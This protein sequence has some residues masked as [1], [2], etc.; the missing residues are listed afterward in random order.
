MPRQKST[1]YFNYDAI[2]A[3]GPALRGPR[4]LAVSLSST[5]P[6]T[7]G[8]T[9][10]RPFS[11]ACFG[12]YIMIMWP[13]LNYSH[14][15]L[16]LLLFCSILFSCRWLDVDAHENN[17]V[18]VD[19]YNNGN[20]NKKRHGSRRIFHR[21]LQ[22]NGRDGTTNNRSSVRINSNNHSIKYN[23]ENKRQSGNTPG[24]T[25]YSINRHNVNITYNDRYD[26]TSTLIPLIINN[27]HRRTR[28]LG[29][30]V[31]HDSS[32]KKLPPAPL[33]Y[34]FDTLLQ[35]QKRYGTDLITVRDATEVYPILLGNGHGQSTHENRDDDCPFTYVSTHV[36]S[37]QSS[38][39]ESNLN[40]NNKKPCY[41][42]IATIH[43]KISNSRKDS[44]P[45]ILLLGGSSP[46]EDLDDTG[47]LS[48]V[49]TVALLLECAHCESLSPWVTGKLNTAAAAEGGGIGIGPSGNNTPE[50][51]IAH[52]N[53]KQNHSKYNNAA[54]KCRASLTSRGITD[55]LRKW[56]ARLVATREIVSLPVADT[57]GYFNAFHRI[58]EKQNEQQQQQQQKHSNGHDFETAMPG[59]LTDYDGGDFPFPLHWKQKQ[60]SSAC[61]LN[62][63]DSTFTPSCM[64]TFSSRLLN[65]VLRSHAFQIG[66]AF[67]TSTHEAFPPR[68]EIP[69]W[70][71]K[72]T[73]T[74]DNTPNTLDER[75]MMDIA[76]AFGDLSESTDVESNDRSNN[77]YSVRINYAE[78]K[79]EKCNNSN[80]ANG[81]MFEPFAFSA[82]MVAGE[83]L[84]A[85]NEGLL[86]MEQC[87]CH[88]L[89]EGG[90]NETHNINARPNEGGSCSYPS[91][92]TSHYDGS[93]LRAFVARVVSSPFATPFDSYDDGLFAAT[94]L[95]SNIRMSLLATELV[96]PYTIIRSVAGVALRDDDAI[97]SSPRVPGACRKTRTIVMPETSPQMKETVVEWT[98]GGALEVAETAIM[99]GKV[100][101]CRGGVAVLVTTRD[102]SIGFLNV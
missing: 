87:Q 8:T 45:Q 5:D 74:Y 29:E 80:H 61:S 98:V 50:I 71:T 20:D 16:S 40:R 72:N 26:D 65:E 58:K 69:S 95:G 17:E 78:Q 82:G 34:M 93:S 12:A 77:L 79:S 88:P 7:T 70:R 64:T 51:H 53:E 46:E 22:H 39:S 55:D 13:S 91:Q 42:P 73:N 43:D 28:L 83:G 75:A 15:T 24:N 1:H 11:V 100:C 18:L 101:N 23:N 30:M 90:H 49:G 102:I 56:L 36:T 48:I 54:I 68:I 89:G 92:Q 99:Y 35:L 96:E 57:E 62:S 3:H 27:S 67:H 76:R 6:A 14:G 25:Q 66:V 52:E 38:N 4:S 19:H 94:T 31:L 37:P 81:A 10:L 9:P 2:R 59:I 84:E 41:T 63:S 33:Q 60:Q 47:P 86:W 44:P 97:P 32:P 85:T 21:I